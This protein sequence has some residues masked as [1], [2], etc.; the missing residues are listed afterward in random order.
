MLWKLLLGVDLMKAKNGKY[1]GLLQLRA[2]QGRL[3]PAIPQATSVTGQPSQ[4][5]SVSL[6]TFFQFWGSCPWCVAVWRE[7]KTWVLS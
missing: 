4:T 6:Q 5:F 7:M 1:Q 3:E 2:L